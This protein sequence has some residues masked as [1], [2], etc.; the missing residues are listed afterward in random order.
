MATYVCPKKPYIRAKKKST[1]RSNNTDDNVKCRPRR[2]FGEIQ[3]ITSETREVSVPCPESSRT[4]L[5]STR[6]KAFQIFQDPEDS[7]DLESIQSN[8]N[9]HK[10]YKHQQSNVLT[11]KTSCL[12]QSS[13]NSKTKASIRDSNKCIQNKE[14]I[15]TNINKN[16]KT[17]KSNMKKLSN[18][19]SLDKHDLTNKI[20]GCVSSQSNLRKTENYATTCHKTQHKLQTPKEQKQLPSSSSEMLQF[21]NTN[22][23]NNCKSTKPGPKG[24]VIKPKQNSNNQNIRNAVGEKVKLMEN[25][26]DTFV[27]K[28]SNTQN[29]TY[30]EQ[31]KENLG[32]NKELKVNEKSNLTDNNK[33]HLSISKCQLSKHLEN[34]EHGKTENLDS[35]KH[36]DKLSHYTKENDKQKYLY[37]KKQEQLSTDAKSKSKCIEEL[38]KDEFIRNKRAISKQINTINQTV[39]K[40]INSSN[41][42][43][44]HQ[45]PKTYH[46]DNLSSDSERAKSRDN[47]VVHCR[48]YNNP[49]ELINNE[50]EDKEIISSDC[51]KTNGNEKICIQNDDSNRKKKSTKKRKL[52]CNSISKN[53]KYE[54]VMSSSD[55][56]ESDYEENAN[57]SVKRFNDDK[58]EK[59]PSQVSQSFK[60]PGER[61][62][63]K[64]LAS[65]SR[66]KVLKAQDQDDNIDPMESDVNE[67][68][69]SLLKNGLNGS[70]VNNNE[71]PLST[72]EVTD[73]ESGQIPFYSPIKYTHFEIFS[74]SIHIHSVNDF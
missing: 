71:M 2:L 62:Y 9:A 12:M 8:S 50:S 55:F 72:P 3:N 48:K 10:K 42:Q 26:L 51:D 53:R 73:H 19:R 1:L 36:L 14:N 58:K 34:C 65:A 68:I 4:N 66:Y 31:N 67:E 32:T 23:S 69:D 40:N 13:Q 44:L 28:P 45:T 15:P 27:R 11:K 70:K 60:K 46:T 43:N 74:V 20:T 5:I 57:L 33:Q 47:S 54:D 64:E 22:I 39:Y 38:R 35:K 17:K 6:K 52:F 29:L 56:E 49:T 63:S 16:K 30:Y 61:D 21:K 25:K 7:S 41:S 24:N 18:L 59:E 37:S